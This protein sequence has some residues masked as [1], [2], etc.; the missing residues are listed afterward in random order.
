MSEINLLPEPKFVPE[1]H[2]TFRPAVLVNRA[3]ETAARDTGAAVEAGIGLEQADGSVFHTRTVLFPEG[4]ALAGNNLR[5]LERLVKFLLW[6]RG[7]WKI[8]VSGADNL[9]PRL[10]EYYRMNVFGKFDDDVIGQKN[11]GHSLEVVAC[12][13]LPAENIQTRAIGRNLDGCRIGFDLGGSDRKAAAVIDG[14]VKFSEEIVWDPYFQEDPE[15][16]YAG[17]VDSLKRAAEHLP[18]VDAIGGSAAGCYSQNRV[19]WASLF[20]GVS[21]EDFEAKV[22]GMFLRIAEEWNV[23]LEVY[24]DGEVT[25]LAGSM[26]LGKNGVL[27]IAMGT[28][29]GGGYIDM[30]G[31]LTTWLSELAF[32]PIDLHPE[33]PADEWSG[34]LGCGAQ[35]FS[36]QA[37]GRLLPVSGI[38]CDASLSLPEQLKIVQAAMDAGD[39]RARK[40]YDAIGIYLG[41]SL[42][43]YA[44]FYDFEYVLLLGRVTSGPG[45]EHIIA[46]SKEVMAAEFPELSEYIKF[47]IPDEMEKRHGQAIAAASLPK[48]R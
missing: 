41:Y 2:P 15:Y 43:H 32:A 12:D 27:G 35:Y 28:S 37:V 7:G 48:I 4:H 26:A 13:E 44:E 24:N 3:F 34:D 10:Q 17:I 8:H 30:D 36:Q 47:H 11:F 20:R 45:G 6:Q 33:A 29:Q 16:H 46:R 14:E 42:A 23:P 9:V 18:R 1:L 38:E 39:E 19:T 31:N 25:A 40:I 22:R 5:H 21:Q